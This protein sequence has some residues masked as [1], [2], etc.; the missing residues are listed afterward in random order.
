M[1]CLE[2]GKGMTQLYRDN[3][4]LLAQRWPALSNYID[5][6][7]IEDLNAQLT[8]GKSQTISINDIQLSSRHNALEEAFFYRSLT[9]GN[10]FH[11]FGFGM[12]DL[13]NLLTQDK[14][15]TKITIYVLHADIFKLVLH[16]SAQQ[17]LTDARFDLQIVTENSSLIPLMSHPGVI[18]LPADKALLKNK[19]PNIYYQLETIIFSMHLN[20][21]MNN[22]ESQKKYRRLET[23]NLA[24]LKK[25]QD[26]K[27]LCQT[28]VKEVILVGAGP[29]L[30]ACQDLLHKLTQQKHRPLIIAVAMACKALLKYGI[31]PDIVVSIDVDVFDTV[32]PYQI[33]KNTCLVYSSRT[34]HKCIKKWRGDRYFTHLTD[35]SY[36]HFN[37]VLPATRLSIFGSVIH[38]AMHIALAKGAK[39]IYI[40]GC[41]FGFPNE[42]AHAELNNDEYALPFINETVINGYGQ[43]IGT[44]KQYRTFLVGMEQMMFVHPKVDYI[45]CSRI[46]ARITG[47]RYLTEEV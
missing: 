24:F 44:D 7:G 42:Q 37:K 26:V 19:L 28:Q 15:A 39:K 34:D 29:S 4:A 16:Y 1:E 40:M 30:E 21:T 36:D 6:Q 45:N 17:W 47:A 31:K 35:P 41:D 5:E 3:M 22:A 46:G 23:D 14:S 9:T 27:A 13:P 43:E 8:E 18:I 25:E 38:P 11:L 20:K 12:G 10:E 2:V 32:I 33:A